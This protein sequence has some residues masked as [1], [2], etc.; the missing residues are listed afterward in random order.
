[1]IDIHK[2]GGCT[3]TKDDVFSKSLPWTTLLNKRGTW[4]SSA[5]VETVMSL[6]NETAAVAQWV[7]AFAPQAEVWAF[8]SQPRQIQVLKTASGSSSVKRS[9]IGVSASET[10]APCHSRCGTLKNPHCCLVSMSAKYRSKFAA[11]HR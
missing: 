6:S 5:L 8:E 10:Y 4:L 3:H 7:R 1:M 2:T 11:P 9:A